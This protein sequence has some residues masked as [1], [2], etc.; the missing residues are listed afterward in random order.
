MRRVIVEISASDEHCG[1]GTDLPWCPFVEVLEGGETFACALIRQATD[2]SP[3]D[4]IAVTQQGKLVRLEACKA[5]EV[6]KT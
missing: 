2:K 6:P 5:S 3:G 4:P 1:D